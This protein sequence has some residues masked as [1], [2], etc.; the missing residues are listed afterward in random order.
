MFGTHVKAPQALRETPEGLFAVL[1][2]G[3]GSK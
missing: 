3:I 1:K 2:A